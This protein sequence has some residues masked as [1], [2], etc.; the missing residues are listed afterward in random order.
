MIS[1]D[2]ENSLIEL[3]KAQNAIFLVVDEK[4]AEDLNYKINDTLSQYQTQAKELKEKLIL[5]SES[6][7]SSFRENRKVYIEDFNKAV[8][9]YDALIN[10]GTSD[11]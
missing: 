6:I 8:F 4:I 1:E 2:L 3:R 7:I 10:K 5:A 9:T 11:E